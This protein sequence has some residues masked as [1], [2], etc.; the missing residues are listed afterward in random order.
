MTTDSPGSIGPGMNHWIGSFE[1]TGRTGTS[2]TGE[3]LT[4]MLVSAGS[5]WSVTVGHGRG[6]PVLVTL[7]ENV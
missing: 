6:S 5:G 3:W 1:L 2:K 4:W 7:I